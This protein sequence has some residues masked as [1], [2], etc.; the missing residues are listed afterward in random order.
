MR[1]VHFFGGIVVIRK[2]NGS[3]SYLNK[4][5]NVDDKNKRT[6]IGDVRCQINDDHI[7]GT[8]SSLPDMVKWEQDIKSEF[9]LE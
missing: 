6:H 9:A 4:Y 8:G 2:T 5:T 3:N 1:I 7:S